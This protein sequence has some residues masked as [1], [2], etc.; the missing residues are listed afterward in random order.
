M[1]TYDPGMKRIIPVAVA[2]SLSLSGCWWSDNSDEEVPETV[3]VETPSA[4]PLS[5]AEWVEICA[6]GSG[7][8]TENPRCFEDL[9]TEYEGFGD[10]DGIQGEWVMFREID[11]DDN[12]HDWSIRVNEIEMTSLIPDGADNPEY[13]DGDLDAPERI[14]AEPEPGLEFLVVGFTARNDGVEP[15]SLPADYGVHLK[16]GEVFWPSSDD[17]FIASNLMNDMETSVNGDHLDP[18]R[19]AGGVTV[20]SVP[21]GSDVVAF[22]LMDAYMMSDFYTTIELTDISR[23]P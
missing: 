12:L 5:Q 23:K 16:D 7:S 21:E 22:E 20:F 2:V 18:G 11:S 15:G 17:E 19:E 6:P 14:D 9:G 4:K 1:Q 8:N 3:A 10:W 13:M